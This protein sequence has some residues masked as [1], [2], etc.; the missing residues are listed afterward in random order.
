MLREI[1]THTAEAEQQCIRIAQEMRLDSI[2][3][4]LK[5]LSIWRAEFLW[6]RDE[7]KLDITWSPSVLGKVLQVTMIP[8]IYLVILAWMIL[9]PFIYLIGV[10]ELIKKRRKL[11]KMAHKLEGSLTGPFDVPEEKTLQAL[12][13]CYGL[14]QKTFT[15]REQIKLLCRWIEILYGKAAMQ[16]YDLKQMIDEIRQRQFAA[17][18][19]YYKGDP[20]APHFFF[21]DPAFSLA[22]KVSGGL[23][24]Y[25]LRH[26][27]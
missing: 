10:W 18:T 21:G 14:E 22:M 9:T 5:E 16:M 26:L 1:S 17:N 8:F 25:I 20:E 24:P 2:R 13:R 15:E 12:W 4:E 6:P 11:T 3:A 23:P 19:P 27:L 7:M